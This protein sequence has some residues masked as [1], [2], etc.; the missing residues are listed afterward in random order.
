VRHL[1]GDASFAGGDVDGA[2]DRIRPE[3]HRILRVDLAER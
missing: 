3:R 2:V 1:S